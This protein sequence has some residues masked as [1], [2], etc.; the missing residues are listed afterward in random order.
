MDD[1][2]ALLAGYPFDVLLGSVHW[3]GAFMF[4]DPAA[5]RPSPSGTGAARRLSGAAYTDGAVRAR[6]NEDLRRPRPPRPRQGAR[7]VPV[8]GAGRGVRGPHRRG[9][10]RLRNVGRGLLGRV[11]Q[12]CGGAVHLAVAA[13]Q[14]GRP[15]R[16]VD[17]GLR[18]PRGGERR[19]PRRRPADPRRGRRLGSLALSPDRG[20]ATTCRSVDRRA[21][22]RAPRR[23]LDA[24]CGGCSSR[25]LFSDLLLYV[26]LR[27]AADGGSRRREPLR[28]P[29]PD[30]P[31][32]EPDALQA[33][34]RR[35]GGRRR[36]VAARPRVPLACAARSCP[37]ER[38]N[39][40]AGPCDTSA[41]PVR[42]HD[43]VLGGAV[44]RL[45]A[46]HRPAYR[47]ARARLRPAVRAPGGD[48]ERRRLFPF[49]SDDE[50][51]EE[52]PRV[53]DG[54]IVA[55]RRRRDH[56]RLAERRQR[57]APDGHRLG[58][59]RLSLAELGVEAGLGARAYTRRT[60]GDRGDRAPPRRRRAV[61]TPSR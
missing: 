26:P 7:T 42:L 10:G 37:V 2:A 19:L 11:A 56:L 59:R 53:G 49:A 34:P 22:A 20:S 13:R 60:A 24:R 27:H 9:G 5:R 21:R 8:A 38:P 45:V 28:R 57:P 32:H 41:M 15:R 31:D 46:E 14:A 23:G 4:D 30:A 17:D 51:I 52:A 40:A 18:H 25:P 50:A 36:R 43:E 55:R 47:R 3:L 33:R 35:P 39:R 1:V 58:D 6:R 48:G 54:V 61:A 12:A 44:P 29:R 16:P